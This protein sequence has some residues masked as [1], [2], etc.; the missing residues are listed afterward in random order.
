MTHPVVHLWEAAGRPEPNWQGKARRPVT[1]PEPRDGVCAL[2]GEPGPVW[3]L[4]KITTTLTTLDRF[5]RRDAD[6]QGLAL[7]PAAAW[8]IRHRA[9]MQ[10]P[11]AI[12]DGTHRQVTPPELYQAL[13]QAATCP[14]VMPTV[15]ISRQKHVLPWARWGHVGVDDEWLP[16]DRTHLDRLGIYR[17]L[18]RLGF[19]EAA[20]A[21]PTPRHQ[22]LARLDRADRIW[23]LTHWGDLNRWRHHPAYLEVAARATREPKET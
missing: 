11:H 10:H 12:V 23:V 21:E 22:I 7:G 14:D 8:A 20:I 5:R 19:G 18:R 13:E 9:A 4:N 16:W 6:P 1:P 17:A 3:P 15:P 2:T